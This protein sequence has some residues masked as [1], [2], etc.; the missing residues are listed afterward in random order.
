MNQRYRGVSNEFAYGQD[1]LTTGIALRLASGKVTG[2]ISPAT[3]I[4]I[5]KSREIVEAIVANHE[6]VYGINTGFG[7]LCTT[8]ISE[9]DTKKLQ[10]NLLKSHSV[11]VG[12]SIEP[13]LAKLMMIL[14]VHAL[15]KGYSGISL[16]TI[17]R[18]IWHINENI[19]PVVPS[20]GSVGASGDLAPLAHLFLP[21]K[22]K[23][24]LHTRF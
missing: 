10:L 14:K 3:A 24:W 13:E 18:I 21:L 8:I 17:E 9:S 5:L 11:G 15:A 22:A 6:I 12:S 19:I 2:S 1:T 7:P 4:R 16:Q 20:Q 23:K